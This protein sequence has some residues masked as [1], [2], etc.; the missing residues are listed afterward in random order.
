MDRFGPASIGVPSM[1][2][3]AGAHAV[4]P[5]ATTVPWVIAVAVLMGIGNGMGAGLVM[6]MGANASPP[7][8]RPAF[9][10]AWRLVGDLGSASG[11]LAV[12]AVAAVT[13]LATASLVMGGIGLV[14]AAALGRLSARTRPGGG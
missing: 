5:L 9:L 3:L 4:L 6:T 10:G 14:A 11:P 1:L 12:S 7:A 2:V 13:T 8:G